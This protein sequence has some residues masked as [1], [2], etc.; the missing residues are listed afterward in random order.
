MEEL[1]RGW[2]G[3]TGRAK[4]RKGGEQRGGK[5]QGE[6]CLSLKFLDPAPSM[7]YLWRGL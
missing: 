5:G 2:R 4:K 1:R 3:G 6:K 7:V